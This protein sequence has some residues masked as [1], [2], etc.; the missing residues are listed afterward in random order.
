MRRASDASERVLV[1]LLDEAL[2]PIGFRR[3]GRTWTRSGHP[4]LAM[5]ALQRE[6]APTALFVNIAFTPVS[7]PPPLTLRQYKVRI[8]AER[9]HDVSVRALRLLDRRTADSADTAADADLLRSGLVDPVA[10]L[11]AGVTDLPSLAGALRSQVSPNVFVHAD[12][13]DALASA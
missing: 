11:V 8:R 4:V 13:R 7:D 1:G 6:S 5:I 9:V 10:R 2:S 12:L 3:R